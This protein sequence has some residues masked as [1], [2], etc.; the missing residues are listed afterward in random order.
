MSDFW[1]GQHEGKGEH[2]GKGQNSVTHKTDSVVIILTVKFLQ[3]KS[4]PNW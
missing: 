1:K 4:Q 3:M 2:E